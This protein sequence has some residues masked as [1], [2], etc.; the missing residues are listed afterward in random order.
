MPTVMNKTY[1]EIVSQNL[2][3]SVISGEGKHLADLFMN[4]D[5]SILQQNKITFDQVVQINNAIS[6]SSTGLGL[7]KAIKAGSGACAVIGVLGL[8]APPVAGACAVVEG[9]S[10][11]LDLGEFLNNPSAQGLVDLGCSTVAS[12]IP[13]ATKGC[14]ILGGIE[15]ISPPSNKPSVPSSDCTTNPSD[16][17]C[18]P[19]P[20]SCPNGLQPDASG[21]CAPSQPQPSPQ[22]SPQPPQLQPSPCDPVYGCQGAIVNPHYD[23]VSVLIPPTINFMLHPKGQF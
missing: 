2:S 15:A 20:P 6:K 17:A 16:P 21:N 14:K 11:L 3:P 22:P 4:E 7:K 1:R 5:P 19:Q 10:L 9:A 23:R 12:K 13:G 18:R 8:A